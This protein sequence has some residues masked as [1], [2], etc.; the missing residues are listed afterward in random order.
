MEFTNSYQFL[1]N[2]QRMEFISESLVPIRE[3]SPVLQRGLKSYIKKLYFFSNFVNENKK[4]DGEKF[5]NYS[6]VFDRKVHVLDVKCRIHYL[7][8]K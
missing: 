8:R 4:Y 3:L 5:D 2:L 1:P 6:T 7:L